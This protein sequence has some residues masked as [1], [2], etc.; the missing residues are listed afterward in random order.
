MLKRAERGVG[1]CTAT[2]LYT[3]VAVCLWETVGAPG[4]RG[5]TIEVPVLGAESS[6][7]GLAIIL[8]LIPVSCVV[9]DFPTRPPDVFDFPDPVPDPC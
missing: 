1:L 8:N 6:L 9:P 2:G 3:A 5:P 7:L 4:T